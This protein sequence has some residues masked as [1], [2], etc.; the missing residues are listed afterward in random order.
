MITRRRF[1]AGSIVGLAGL[2]G[3]RGALAQEATPSG[4]ESV[5]TV[6]TPVVLVDG[7]IVDHYRVANSAFEGDSVVLGSVTNAR[8]ETVAIP[9]FGFSVTVLDKERVILGS[10]TPGPV[11]P[12]IPPGRSIGF[13]AKF[14]DI[15]AADIDTE[16]VRFE[17][18]EFLTD[19]PVIGQLAE[20]TIEI[21][22]EEEVSRDGDNLAIE[23]VVRNTSDLE[24]SGLVL[25]SAIWDADWYFC[26]KT[27]AYVHTTLQPG[28]AI[29]FTTQT[30]GYAFNPL[31][32]AGDDFTVEP[33]I[34]P[35]VST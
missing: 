21:E 29:R 18:D 15:V 30:T 34:V 25:E 35:T 20:A 5:A 1:A 24:Y 32:V 8:S 14:T 22:S 17:S 12:I 7:I 23:Y 13:I 2:R 11:Y 6:T 28:D 10:A 9:T 31:T 26:G 3:G 33:W 19:A 4:P 16:S 27:T